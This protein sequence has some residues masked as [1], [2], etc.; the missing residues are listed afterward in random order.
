[1]AASGGVLV[2]V[3]APQVSGEIIWVFLPRVNE[4]GLQINLVFAIFRSW[5]TGANRK[6]MFLVAI[7]EKAPIRRLKEIKGLCYHIH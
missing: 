6:N 1:M 4:E 7:A 3:N 5:S 2:S